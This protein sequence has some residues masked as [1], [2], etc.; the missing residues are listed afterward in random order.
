MLRTFCV[1][2][3]SAAL[4]M[5]A[6]AASKRVDPTAAESAASTPGLLAGTKAAVQLD[7]ARLLQ[8][9]RVLP[10]PSSGSIGAFSAPARA[11]EAPALAAALTTS[12]GTPQSVQFAHFML[13]LQLL[14]EHARSFSASP[15][16]GG[17]SDGPHDD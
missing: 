17:S 12:F 2:A 6:P 3:C 11:S 4:S 7:T 1:F 16:W 9:L 13:V 15:S 10:D 8:P 5:A 14:G